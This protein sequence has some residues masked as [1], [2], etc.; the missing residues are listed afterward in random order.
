MDELHDNRMENS[1]SAAV[2]ESSRGLPPLPPRAASLQRSPRRTARCLMADWM[3]STATCTR[4][5]RSS[6]SASAN[7]SRSARPR[8]SRPSFPAFTMPGA[9]PD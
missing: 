9:R 7:A 8:E 2:E 6:W 1:S 5:R 3:A 4:K